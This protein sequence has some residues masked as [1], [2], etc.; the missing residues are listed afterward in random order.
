VVSVHHDPDRKRVG[1][2]P[3]PLH[4]NFAL[5]L[6]QKVL[7]VGA[8]LGMYSDALAA[9]HV[10]HD[11]FAADG[12]AAL[13]AIYQQVI[14]ALYANNGVAVVLS[15]RQWCPRNVFSGA[16]LGRNRGL[17][18]DLLGRQLLEY[19]PGGELP[20]AQRGVQI[21]DLA[22]AVLSGYFFQIG[23][24]YLAQLH[25]QP[26]G[27]FLQVLFAD[28]DGLGALTGVD[29]V[30]DLVP[31]TRSLDD[32]EPVFAGLVAGLRQDLD[33]VAIAQRVAQRYDP[34]VDF[35]AHA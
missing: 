16:G 34:A 13:G 23:V 32:G 30:L 28:L 4:I 14:D 7:H 12:I 25:A 6:I 22:D 2:V 27:F 10:A 18:L 3:R 1:C 5:H 9:R 35:G 33:D 29:Q 26:A 24:R 21:L 31:R 19:L 17:F 11:D 20:V 15:R 8:H